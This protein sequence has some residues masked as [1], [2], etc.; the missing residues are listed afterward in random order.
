V[1]WFAPLFRIEEES[2][3]ADAKDGGHEG[4]YLMTPR[5]LPAMK[6]AK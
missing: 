5:W 2:I 6:S 3:L 1:P 4:A